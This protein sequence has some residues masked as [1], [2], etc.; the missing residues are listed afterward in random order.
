M[1]ILKKRDRLGDILEGAIRPGHFRGVA[2]V[3]AKLFHIV[4]PHRAY[5]GQKDY[6]QCVVVRRMVAGLDLDVEVTVLPT[7]RE[8][9]GLAMSSRNVYLDPEQRRRAAALSRAL[10]AGAEL[11]ASG[12]REAEKVRQAMRT[13][14]LA[15]Q[16]VAVDY[17]EVADPDTL[18]PLESVRGRAVL[19]V[20]AR[21]GP[22][23]LIDNLL[24]L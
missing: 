11:L 10:R 8:P 24:V 17:A 6:Q 1:P 2:T 4:Q 13:V 19:L 3:V 16:G 15:E 23:R 9:D 22:T 18:T 12:V 20:A 7:V 5:F 14:L 21:V